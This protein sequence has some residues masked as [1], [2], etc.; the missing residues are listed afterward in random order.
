[1]SQD[2]KIVLFGAMNATGDLRKGFNELVQAIQALKTGNVELVVFGSEKPES[3]HNFGFDPIYLGHLFD[4]LSLRITYN[5]ADVMVVPSRQE[6]LSNAIMESLACGTPVVGFDIGGN[7]DMIE[8]K[9]NGYLA[10]PF[11]PLD[12]AAGIDWVLTNPNYESL[13]RNA[14]EKVIREFESSLVAKKYIRLYNQILSGKV[15]TNI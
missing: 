14:R 10:T 8:H 12:L 7:S 11:K 4:D 9:R 13:R 3:P 6:N 1:L 15:K 5:A 2:K